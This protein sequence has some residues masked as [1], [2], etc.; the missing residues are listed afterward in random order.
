MPKQRIPLKLSTTLTLMVSAIIASVLLVVFALFFVQ[1][2]QEGQDQLQQKAMAI[3][4]TLALS[5]TVVDGLE[6][7]DRS[8]EIQ[9]FAEQVRKQSEL[10]FVV[11][12]DMKGIR[13]S[14]PKPWRIGQH[15]I[16]ED[17]EPAL[18]GKT[19]SAITRGSLGPSLRVFVPVYDAQRQQIG[20]VSLGI[21]LDTVHRVVGESRW[22]IYWTI[23]FA[24]LVGTLGTFF[25]VKALKRIMLGFEPYEIS[26]LF[27]QR[28]AMLQSIKEGVIAV[29][30]QSRIT[31]VNDE[32]KRLLRQCGPL[33]NLLMESASKHWPTQLH[34]AE[35][36]ANGKPLRDRQISFNG[37][38]LLTNTVPVIVKGQVIGAIATF[39]DKTEVSQLVQ[40]LSGM[41]HYADALRVQSHEFMNKLHVILGMLH[42]KAYQQLENY[43]INTASNYQ[44]E[45]GALLRKIQSPEVAGFFIGKISR[46]HDTGIELIID[47]ASLLPE[48]DD[49]ETTHVLISVLGNLIENAIDAIDGVEGHEIN[50]S[51]HHNGDHLHCIVSDDGPGIDPAIG[52]RIFEQGFSTKGPR[53]GIGLA[54]IRSSLEKLG[55]SIDFDSEPG[56]LTQFFVHIPYQ[57]KG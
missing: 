14:H 20:V 39:R 11:V 7:Q 53:R 18:H 25:L 35:V 51:F 29:D 5:S 16:G 46:A 52:T 8:G 49:A 55:G 30:N 24:A 1:M 56:E 31:I 40:R 21:A 26:N 10:L 2:N 37:S 22:I 36:L 54:L 27:E 15:F 32:A 38:E 9:R 19:N 50:L 3:A 28:N 48:T 43:I 12:V 33:E 45:I 13:Y 4:N 44:E 6:R 57:A 17:L 23:A 34:L 42:M 41:S 47:E